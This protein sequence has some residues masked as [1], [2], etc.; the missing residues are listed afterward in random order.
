MARGRTGLPGERRRPAYRGRPRAASSRFGRPWPS[1]RSRMILL[2]D[3]HGRVDGL[4]EAVLGPF[5]HGRGGCAAPPVPRTPGPGGADPAGDDRA[6]AAGPAVAVRLRL[7]DWRTRPG[8]RPRRVRGDDADRP[9]AG[10]SPGVRGLLRAAG[11]GAAGRRAHDGAR[12]DPGRVLLPRVPA[13]RAAPRRGSDRGGH[14]H[15]AVRVRPPRQARGGD[16]EHARAA[17]S[18]TAGS[19]GGRARCCGAG[20]PTR[21]SCRSR[22]SGRALRR[23]RPAAERRGTPRWPYP[24]THAP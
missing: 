10:P 11:D 9:G 12:G 3:Y 5:G 4:V 1:S 23:R 2:L 24:R 7:G 8:H 22:S 18:S 16:A 17:A 21:G 6:G 15:A 19:T 13:V 20:S 14:R